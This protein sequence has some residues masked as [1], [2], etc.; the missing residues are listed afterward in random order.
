MLGATNSSKE[1]TARICSKDGTGMQI[2]IAK[3]SQNFFFLLLMYCLRFDDSTTRSQ[4]RA[5]DKLAPI[6]NIH[7]KFIAVSEANCTPGICCT[8][9]KS[10]HGFREMC[11]FK[12]YIPHKPS[13]CGINV[14]VLA[15]SNTFYSVSF[16]IYTGAGTHAQGLPVPTQAVLDLVLSGSR[17]NRNIT[18]D[19]YYKSVSLAMELKSRKLT[20]VGTMKNKK[21]CSPPSFL[22]EAHEGT[23]QYAFDHEN[24][25]TLLSGAPKKNKRVVFQSTM[26][27]EKKTDVDTEKGEINVFYNQEKG[28]VDSHNQ[29]YGLHTTARKTN[30]W[31]MKFFNG[32]IDSAALNAFVIFTENAPNFGEHKK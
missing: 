30:R 20:L 17:T 24:N 12:Q 23:V 6:R 5:D 2:C 8:I 15:G 29:M 13:K 21:F 18:T 9:D 26:H 14:F 31:Q 19:N 28:G 22:A 3:T 11:D 4:R 1:S 16:K 25:F 10:L 32:M 7:D 27:S